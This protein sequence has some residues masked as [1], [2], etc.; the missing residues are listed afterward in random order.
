MAAVEHRDGSGP[1]TS[2]RNADGTVQIMDWLD[3]KDLQWPDNV[4]KPTD[5]MPL[6]KE[7]LKVRLAEVEEVMKALNGISTGDRT[8]WDQSLVKS[9]S[10]KS[11]DYSAWRRVNTA[12]PLIAGHSF[13]GATLFSALQDPRFSFTKGVALDPWLERAFL[14]AFHSHYCLYS[15]LSTGAWERKDRRIRARDRQRK[16]YGLVITLCDS[17]SLTQ[18]DRRFRLDNNR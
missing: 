18:T 3:H 2:V 8:V 7:Q 15:F 13:G 9:V 1:S 10:R 11:F 5:G 16:L 12:A 14:R 6:R 17:A 4:E